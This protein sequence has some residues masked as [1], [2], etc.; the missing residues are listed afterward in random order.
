MQHKKLAK[1]KLWI[2]QRHYWDLWGIYLSNQVSSG[3]TVFDIDSPIRFQI[4]I[5]GSCECLPSFSLF[6]LWFVHFLSL[7]HPQFILGSLIHRIQTISFSGSSYREH[8]VHQMLEN[9]LVSLV[10]W[11]FQS[12]STLSHIWKWWI[13][14]I[15]HIGTVLIRSL[16]FRIVHFERCACR[17]VFI[18]RNDR[19]T[20]NL[21]MY[22]VSNFSNPV[23]L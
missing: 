17:Q 18:N 19:L 23:D 3:W 20:Q 12:P 5:V 6:R 16:I 14:S 1:R 22:S 10:R 7:F 9:S 21:T 13:R 4:P 2:S 15:N 11:N 8:M